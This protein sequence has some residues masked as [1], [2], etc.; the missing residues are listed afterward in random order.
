MAMPWIGVGLGIAGAW[1]VSRGHPGGGWMIAGAAAALIADTL[2][3]ALFAR[4]AVGESDQ[5]DLNRRAIQLVGRQLV[6]AEPI[7]GGRGKVR[8]GDTLWPAEGPDAPAGATVCV[9]GSNGTALLVAPVRRAQRA[10]TGD[11]A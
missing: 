6:V 5:P 10:S 2:I 3:D 8:A 9:T 7:E 4:F 11:G 1:H